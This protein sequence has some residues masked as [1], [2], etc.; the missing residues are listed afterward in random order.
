M[1]TDMNVIDPFKLKKAKEEYEK[2]VGLMEELDKVNKILYNN[3][4]D[5]GIWRLL[6]HIESIRFDYSMKIM[7]YRKTIDNKGRI[8]E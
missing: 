3:L 1:G 4:E 2:L 5:S 6:Q 8:D 7:H